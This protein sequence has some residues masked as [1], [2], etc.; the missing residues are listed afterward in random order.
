MKLTVALECR[1]HHHPHLLRSSNLRSCREICQGGQRSTPLPFVPAVTVECLPTLVFE[2]RNPT[3]LDTPTSYRAANTKHLLCVDTFHR[4]THPPWQHWKIRGTPHSPTK[5][6]RLKDIQRQSVWHLRGR[7]GLRTQGP[8]RHLALSIATLS[9]NI[10]TGKKIW[11]GAEEKAH[12]L[13]TLAALPEDPCSIPSPRG[14]SRL[15]NSSSKGYDA[16]SWPPWEL[17]TYMHR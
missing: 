11:S 6:L 12:R 14:S 10:D 7:P 5:N 16:L 2:Y 4:L 9:S 1:P 13:W 17:D 8:F 3:L 15:W